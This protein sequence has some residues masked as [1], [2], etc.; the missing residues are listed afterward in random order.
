[1]T[2]SSS[3]ADRPHIIV[4]YTD[5][6]GFGDVGFNGATDVATPHLDALAASGAVMARWYSNSPVCS[7]SRAALLTGRHPIHAGV[8][9][10]L[11]SDRGSVHGLL[12]QPTLASR[13]AEAGYRTSLVGKWHLGTTEESHPLRSGFQRFFGFLAGC[14]DYYSHIMYWGR[15]LP[16]HDLWEQS[17]EVWRNGRYLT[18]MITETACQ[19]IEERGDDPFFLMVSYNAPHYPLHAPQEYV[20]RFGH[21]PD[22]RRMIAAMIAAV[23]DGVGELVATLEREGLRDNT[24]IMFS[25]DNG[26]S[27]EARN[28]LNG[29]ELAFAGGSTGG[30]RGHK[31]SLYEGGIRVPGLWSWP[32]RIPA[33]QTLHASCQ[34]SDVTPTLLSAAGVDTADELDGRSLL[35][36]LTAESDTPEPRLLFWEYEGQRAVSDGDWKLVTAP[37]DR[38]GSDEDTEPDALF[39]LADDPAE[40]RNLIA[41]EPTQ[42]QRLAPALTTFD[43][44]V[45]GWRERAVR[46]EPTSRSEG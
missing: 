13:L 43:A 34:M 20:D 30:L 14:V 21:L 44:R 25:S 6:L 27:A 37:R 8:G 42:R 35:P 18:H 39:C 32:A 1:M 15:T 2:P 40:T 46:P 45:T 5:D 33:G 3:A 10:I 29:D 26:P 28:W 22:D 9:A 17:D 36:L 31:G 16:V 11:G 4:I 7:P 41:S 12:P 24:V 23:D 19:V 38:L